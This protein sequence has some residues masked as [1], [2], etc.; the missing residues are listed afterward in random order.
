MMLFN[1]HTSSRPG[2]EA[3][4]HTIMALE[5]ACMITLFEMDSHRFMWQ[6]FTM[7]LFDFAVVDFEFIFHCLHRI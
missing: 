1:S 3:S 4:K 2:D 6:N 5:E 7:R